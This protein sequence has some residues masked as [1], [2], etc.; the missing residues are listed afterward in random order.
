MRIL[1]ITWLN[2]TTTDYALFLARAW[3]ELGHE[4]HLLAPEIENTAHY[5][6][7]VPYLLAWSDP[8]FRQRVMDRRTE[9]VACSFQPD[10]TL[11]GG[12]P[13]ISPS[14]MARLRG[15]TSSRIGYVIS[16]NHLFSTAVVKAIQQSDFL[17]VHDTYLLPLLRGTRYGRREHVFWRP[18]MADPQEHRPL[19][20]SA[21][22]RQAYGAE[23]AFIGGCGQSRIDTLQPLAQHDLR[24][25]GGR[26]WASVPG[27]SACFRDEPVY[28]L[29]KTKIYNAAQ[30][31]INM[32]DGEKQINAFSERV[33]EVLACGGFV[34]TEWRQDL[35]RTPLI[36]G[37]SFAIYHDRN[38]LCE[39]VRHY[40]A[41]PAERQRISE[42][43]R[44]I[45][46]REMTY[47]V[48]A[49]KLAQQFEAVLAA[50]CCSAQ[51]QG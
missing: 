39:K 14:C 27:L 13:L 43:G 40:L 26:Q 44:R 28:G 37:E 8:L 2:P 6:S 4:V 50:R 15:L 49:A 25:W 41:H 10:L 5:R 42:A 21:W 34:L 32:E 23:I 12:S 19:S 47:A 11:V 51:P 20:L 33:P 35:E 36:D 48:G 38:D 22:D 24:I 16:Y 9:A 1:F 18:S 30:I 3:Q 45:V 31:V 46:L 17:L 7:G 29:K